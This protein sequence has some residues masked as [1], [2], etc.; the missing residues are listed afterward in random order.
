VVGEGREGRG[1]GR[2]RGEGEG[3]R[4]GGACLQL[5][6]V[7]PR[8]TLDQPGQV[9]RHRHSAGRER[10]GSLASQRRAPPLV[11]R[12]HHSPPAV[13]SQEVNDSSRDRY[14]HRPQVQQ[15]GVFKGL[16]KGVRTVGS[17]WARGGGSGRRWAGETPPP[18][19]LHHPV[20]ARPAPCDIESSAS[21]AL[22]RSPSAR[23]C[24]ANGFSSDIVAFLY[25]LG[26]TIHI[27]DLRVPWI[28]A[29]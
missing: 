27:G 5:P 29:R 6:R 17:R 10:D 13:R 15:S 24:A 7:L 23:T 19:L 2:E 11:R 3:G 12:A 9:G 16:F 22:G 4:G 1:E 14:A 28:P 18:S 26:F 8:R 25:W 21:T 20:D